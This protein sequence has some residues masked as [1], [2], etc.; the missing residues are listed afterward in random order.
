MASINRSSQSGPIE[1]SLLSGVKPCGKIMGYFMDRPIPEAVVDEFGKRYDYVG[2]APVLPNGQFDAGALNPGEFILQPGV[3][4]RIEEMPG[5]W[6]KSL[7]H[8]H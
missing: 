8:L 4:Y 1:Y 5:S 2:I 6:L 3:I 7:F